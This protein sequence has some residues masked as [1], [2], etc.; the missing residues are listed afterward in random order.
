MDEGAR[1]TTRPA[2]IRRT[3]ATI[4]IRWWHET[5]APYDGEDN[6]A[7]RGTVLDLSGRTLGH[8]A[9]RDPLLDLIRDITAR[10]P[11]ST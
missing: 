7:L 1:A 4:I 8:F 6:R 11:A 9:G 5:G 2:A 3:G 10:D